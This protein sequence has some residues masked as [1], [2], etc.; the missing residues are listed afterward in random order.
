M[1]PFLHD[2]AAKLSACLAVGSEVLKATDVVVSLNAREQGEKFLDAA[3]E[4]F[5][6]LNLLSSENEVLALRAQLQTAKAGLH[7]SSLEPGDRRLLVGAVLRVGLIVASERVRVHLDRVTTSLDEGR[8][9]LKDAIIEAVADGHL[10]PALLQ[11]TD[12]PTVQRCWSALSSINTQ[13]H[14][15]L[16]VQASLHPADIG[17]LLIEVSEP[18]L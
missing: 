18:F 10:D 5:R 9:L 4:V 14:R 6:V 8:S 17:L 3:A 7:P 2:R 12:Q 15:V 1:L 11:I 16:R 13:R